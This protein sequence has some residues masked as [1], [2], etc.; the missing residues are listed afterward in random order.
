[1]TRKI[2]TIRNLILRV[3][4]LK[5]SIP[6]QAPKGPKNAANRSLDSGILQFPLLL[7]HLSIPKTTKV[8][9]FTTTIEI[10]T[11]KVGVMSIPS[12]VFPPFLHDYFSLSFQ[13]LLAFLL[14]R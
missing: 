6:A 9:V 14:I 7:F 12:L 8:N 5:R 11:S 3:L 2:G 13:A 1:M 10:N 4:C